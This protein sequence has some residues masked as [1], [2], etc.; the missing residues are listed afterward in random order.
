MAV[1][2]LSAAAAEKVSSL[3]G[4]PAVISGRYT[5][6]TH[7]SYSNITAQ[8]LRHS[9]THACTQYHHHVEEKWRK[10]VIVVVIVP[11]KRSRPHQLLESASWCC[12]HQWA[13]RKSW[14]MQFTHSHSGHPTPTQG[15]ILPHTNW[16]ALRAF[17]LTILVVNSFWILQK[18]VC[19]EKRD[20]TIEP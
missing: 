16:L 6:V 7:Y 11:K 10:I 20:F 8:Q 3:T 1:P 13:T 5:N 14:H 9:N 19:R 4:G 2:V 17:S 18:K 15:S 12:W